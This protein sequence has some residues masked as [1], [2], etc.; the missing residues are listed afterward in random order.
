[1]GINQQRGLIGELLFLEYLIDLF[2]DEMV[3]TWA[4]PTDSYDS[5]HDFISPRLHFE[6]LNQPQQTSVVD[7]NEIGT[8]NRLILIFRV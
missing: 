4:G 5:I 8:R 6:E 7:I 3:T 1:M 2:G